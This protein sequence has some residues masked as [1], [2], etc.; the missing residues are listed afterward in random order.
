VGGKISSLV[1]NEILRA[2]N[3]IH[4]KRTY[5]YVASSSLLSLLLGIIL[6]LANC[7]CCCCRRCCGIQL[8]IAIA[9]V[10]V[11]PRPTRL[12]VV[13]HRVVF[14]APVIPI[15]TR[16]VVVQTH[17]ALVRAQ[18]GLVAGRQVVPPVDAETGA[19]HLHPRVDRRVLFQALQ[20]GG[21]D[22]R[23]EQQK[24]ALARRVE[25]RAEALDNGGVALSAQRAQNDA[26]GAGAAGTLNGR[27]SQ[28]VHLGVVC[29][30][31][32]RKVRK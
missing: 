26:K 30:M 12:R 7:G 32:G 18:H 24:V 27:L 20:F 28:L 3:H 11:A 22:F 17:H 19:G 8:S 9:P 13:V 23:Q 29:G 14:V 16:G 10:V 25:G 1:P 4:E 6:L 31:E 2:N 5:L 15:I 21:G